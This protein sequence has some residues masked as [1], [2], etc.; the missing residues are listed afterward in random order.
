MD[1]VDNVIG[2]GKINCNNKLEVNFTTQEL[3]GLYHHIFCQLNNTVLL[4]PIK[5]S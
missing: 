5:N 4:D 1:C 2:N 3:R